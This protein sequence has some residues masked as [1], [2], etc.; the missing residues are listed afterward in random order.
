MIRLKG[1]IPALVTL[2]ILGGLGIGAT[3]WILWTFLKVT[4]D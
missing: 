4:F 1:A 3:A 2:A